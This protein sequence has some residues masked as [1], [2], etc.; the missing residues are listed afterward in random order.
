[1]KPNI[2]KFTE[3]NVYT[4]IKMSKT[5]F[6]RFLNYTRD[7]NVNSVELANTIES[8]LNTKN[9]HITHHSDLVG[10]LA[11]VYK[12]KLY[13]ELGLHVGDT[14]KKVQPHVVNGIGVEL[15]PNKFLS[16][17]NYSN[18][19][20]VYTSTDK[21]FETYDSAI[22]QKIDM[23]FIDADHSFE[24]AL[25]DFNN[26]FNRLS[27]NGV[28]MM[29]DTDPESDELFIS[30]RCG[31]SYKIVNILEQRDDINIYTIPLFEAGLSIITKKSNTRTYNRLNM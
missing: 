10:I 22:N 4:K 11:S 14:F 13:I 30:S 21:F 16:N 3:H 23:A 31:D 1:M 20:I 15:V 9:A 12:P 24:S 19:Q 25:K 8:H 28:I 7:A 2:K 17:L 18:L 6:I 26:V 29:H 27:D 5:N